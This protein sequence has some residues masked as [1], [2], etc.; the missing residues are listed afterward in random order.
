[1]EKNKNETLG[2]R[3]IRELE[4]LE[5]RADRDEAA[6]TQETMGD[7]TEALSVRDKLLQRTRRRIFET[8]IDMIDEQGKVIGEIIVKTRMLTGSE[9]ARA[10]VLLK[11][12]EIQSQEENRDILKFNETT[13]GISEI[14]AEASVDADVR[15]YFSKGEATDDVL[16]AVL[17]STMEQ[18]LEAMGDSVQRFREERNRTSPT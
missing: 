1:M 15:E 3:N 7:V 11:E 4:E 16:I 5:G 10:I 6:E 2:E 8:P 12:L 17:S 9:R 18:S 13:K 14:L